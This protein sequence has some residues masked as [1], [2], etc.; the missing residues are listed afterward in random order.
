[1]GIAQFMPGTWVE[2]GT[3][4][5]GNGAASPFDPADAIDAQGRFMCDLL[6]R[7]SGLAGDPVQLALAGYNAGWGAVLRYGGIPPY[8][9]TQDYIARIT[10]M[11]AQFRAAQ[12]GG[13]FAD[14]G[15][16]GP[17]P[18]LPSEPTR[19]DPSCAEPSPL[20]PIQL[21]CRSRAPRATACR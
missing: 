1:M 10:A 16:F 12:S 7:A 19:P 9:E 17:S 2:W 6:R 14:A 5:D 13:S 18:P 4:V 15:A 3:D 11:A 8:A 21:G 20:V